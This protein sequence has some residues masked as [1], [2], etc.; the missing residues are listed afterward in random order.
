VSIGSFLL[1]GN[2]WITVHRTIWH[3]ASL[4]R[5]CQHSRAACRCCGLCGASAFI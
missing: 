4:W 3:V 1:F 2:R 5:I